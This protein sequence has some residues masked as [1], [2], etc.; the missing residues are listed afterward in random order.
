M[1][2]SD[3]LIP[4][5]FDALFVTGII[6]LLVIILCIKNYKRIMALNYY[7]KIIILTAIGTAIGVHGLIHLGLE[8]NYNFNPYMW[9]YNRYNSIY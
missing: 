8:Q 2:L 5:S 4:P 6:M 3:Y 1:L 7:Q 9:F